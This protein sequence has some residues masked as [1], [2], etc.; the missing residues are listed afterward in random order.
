MAKKE[1][2]V[3]HIAEEIFDIEPGTTLVEVNE[4]ESK[5]LVP[6]KAYDEKDE[7]LEEQFDEIRKTAYD[8]FED[9]KSISD[10]VEPKYSARNAEV[11]AQYLRM[12][13]DAIHEKAL[14]KQNKDKNTKAAPKNVTNNIITDRNELLRSLQAAEEEEKKRQDA[15][16]GEAEVIEAEIVDK[17]EES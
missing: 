16:D 9:Q 2:A 11:A 6:V 15:I 4:S 8:A 13:L 5:D 3:E 14:M 7:E 17:T 12:A 10:D 1:K